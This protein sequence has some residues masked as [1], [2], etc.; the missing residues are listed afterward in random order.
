M[1]DNLPPKIF[2]QQTN[3]DAVQRISDDLIDAMICLILGVGY[4]KISFFVIDWIIKGKASMSLK[5][6]YGKIPDIL[7]SCKIESSSISCCSIPKYIQKSKA[8]SWLVHFIVTI[9]LIS[10][11]TMIV[12]GSTL[13]QY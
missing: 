6:K 3:R 11:V 7:S 5:E 9:F 12:H 4:R 1:A 13:L 10:S 2:Y 8:S